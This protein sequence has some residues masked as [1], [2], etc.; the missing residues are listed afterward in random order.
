MRPFGIAPRIDFAAVEFGVNL[1]FF[2]LVANDFRQMAVL[3]RPCDEIDIRPLANQIF[4][5][6][7]G[8]APHDAD[9]QIGLEALERQ[10]VRQT[11]QNPRLRFFAHRTGVQNNDVGFIQCVRRFKPGFR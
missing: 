1:G 10:Q 9:H 6:M 3:I 7:F 2:A 8:H 11:P 4:P 5:E